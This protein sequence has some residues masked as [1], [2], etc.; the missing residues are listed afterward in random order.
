MGRPPLPAVIPEGVVALE[1]KAAELEVQ[2]QAPKP[3]LLGRHLIDLGM[4]PSPEFKPILDAAYEA[5]L[6]GRFNTLEGA[7]TWFQNR[8]R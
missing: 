6:E 3:I 2:S 5:Q 8:E 7:I 1:A 4:R